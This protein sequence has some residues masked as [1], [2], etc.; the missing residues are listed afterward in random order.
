MTSIVG[1]LVMFAI[2]V[3]WQRRQHRRSH[4]CR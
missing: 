2:F 3:Y 4:W 1:G